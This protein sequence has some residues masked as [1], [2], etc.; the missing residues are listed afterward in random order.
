MKNTKV[1]NMKKYQS[2]KYEKIQSDK[3]EKIPKL[4]IWKIQQGNQGVQ[5]QTSPCFSISEL[6]MQSSGMLGSIC[7]CNKEYL[8]CL[9]FLIFIAGHLDCHH[10]PLLVLVILGLVLSQ[11]RFW[12]TNF[13][14]NIARPGNSFDVGFRVAFQ[15]CLQ[16][17]ISRVIQ[18]AK[19]TKYL[20]LVFAS[21]A[22]FPQT[23]QV[24]TFPFL[25]IIDS[26]LDCGVKID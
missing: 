10:S 15:V 23:M 2:Y 6:I 21:A 3:Y 18:Q 20:T 4:Q 16:K 14:T 9:Y 5:T 19:W 25:S 12:P 7:C 22:I 8:K 1:T 17:V 24:Q 11:S 26:P 13:S